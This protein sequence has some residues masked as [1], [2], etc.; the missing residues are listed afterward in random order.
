MN[1]HVVIMAGGIGSRFW[2]LSTPEYPKQFIDILGC[3]HTLIQLTVDRFKGVCPMENFWVVTNAAY[4]LHR[5]GLLA[6]K[7][8]GAGVECGGDTCRRRSD[9]PRG[10][11]TCDKQRFGIHF[12]T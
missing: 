6:D 11:S 3:G 7:G 12:E 2:P 10:V 5:M 4:A 9:E 1:T 8:G